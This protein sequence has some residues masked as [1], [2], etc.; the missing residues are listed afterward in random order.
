M[1]KYIVISSLIISMTLIPSLAGVQALANTQSFNPNSN[2]ASVMSALQDSFS[3]FLNFFKRKPTTSTIPPKIETQATENTV[4]NDTNTNEKNTDNTSTDNKDANSYNN[5]VNYPEV[6]R[7]QIIELKSKKAVTNI[8]GPNNTEWYVNSTYN[9]QWN[10]TSNTEFAIYLSGGGHN[11]GYT[12]LI[13]KTNNT[14]LNYKVTESDLPTATGYTWRIIVCPVGQL[15]SSSLCSLSKQFTVIKKTSKNDDYVIITLPA[16]PTKDPMII[17]RPTTVTPTTKTNYAPVINNIAS[18]KST[19]RVGEQ[20]SW[21]VYATDKEN[22]TLTYKAYWR[23]G[24]YA[25]NVEEFGKDR[26]MTHTYNTPGT[27]NIV[28]AVTDSAG[29]V[30]PASVQVNIATNNNA[31]SPTGTTPTSDIPTNTSDY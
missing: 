30:T 22:D 24:Q 28:F 29:N 6:N 25:N 10:G 15:T 26:T 27:Y 1:K 20:A 23:D 12:R 18:T 14:S 17:S 13:G 9:I 3:S 2:Y 21:T 19:L 16:D 31:T 8:I 4:T 11:E 7:D 5:I